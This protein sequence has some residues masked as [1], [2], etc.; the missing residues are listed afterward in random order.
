MTSTRPFNR[1]GLAIAGVSVI[2]LTGCGGDSDVAA[3]TTTASADCPPAQK[4][5]GI[6][7]GSR[8]N[9][10]DLLAANQWRT[11]MFPRDCAG[12]L[13]ALVPD[14]PAGYGVRPNHKPYVMNNDQVYVAY[15]ALPEPLYLGEGNPNIP[16]DLDNIDYE[17]VRF[18]AEEIATLRDW[19]TQNPDNYIAGEIGGEPVYFLGGF[20]SGRPGRGDRLSTSL[21]AFLADNIVVRVSHKGLFSQRGKLEPPPLVV[22]VMSDIIDRSK[23]ASQ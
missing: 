15:A 5:N 11:D 7:V 4:G 19:M 22:A 6:R 12:E 20:G 17:I 2:G 13:G 21:H 9:Y 16:P 8:Y 18:T 10:E 23:Q 3:T 14:L 1:L